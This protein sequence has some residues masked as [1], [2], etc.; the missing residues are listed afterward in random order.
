MTLHECAAAALGG[1][2]DARRFATHSFIELGGDSLRA[3]R[4]VALARERLGVRIPVARLLSGAPLDEILAD[5][6]AADAPAPVPAAPERAAISATQRGMW[7]I[8][9]F[10]GGSPYNLVFACVT[11]RGELAEDHLATAVQ[12]TVDRHE[13]LRTVFREEDGDVVR[14]VVTPFAAPFTRYVDDGAAG[15]FDGFVR[16]IAT[17]TGRKPFDLTAAP[18]VRFAFL[19]GTGRA[20]LVVQAHHM[21][22]D[23]W[24]VGLLLKE[25]FTRYDALV[26]GAADPLPEAGIGVRVLAEHQEATRGDRDRQLAFW[27]TQ[28]DGVPSVLELPADR[29]RP[30]EQ[31]ASGA[32]LPLDL[33][34]AVSDAVATRANTLGV[35]RFAV[36]LAAFGLTLS[37][38][39]GA[40][41]LLIGVPLTGRGTSELAE[42]V[43]VTGNLVPVRVDV[44]DD[45]PAAEYVRSVQE[46]LARSMEAGDLPFEEIVA[47]LGV[48]RTLGAHPLVQVCFGMHDQLVPPRLSTPDV[49]LRVDELHGG[50]AQFDLTLLI[51][52]SE[53]ALAGHVE[54]ATAVWSEAEASAFAADFREA[55]GQLAAEGDPALEEVRCL[56]P[57]RR[58]LLTALNETRREF[59]RVTLDALFRKIAGERP[60]APAVRAGDTELSYAE[61]ARAVR[62][63]AELLRA[64]GV[65][66]GDRVLV[67]LD[68]SIAEVVAVLGTVSVGAAYVGVELDQP[69]AHTD[70]ILASAAPAAALV[71]PRSADRVR[72]IPVVEAWRADWPAPAGEPVF[73]GED[74]DRPAYVAFT[75]GSTGVPK[76]VVVPQR[77]VLRLV[78][79][80]GYVRLGPGERMLRLS[81][82]AFDAST[83][84][85]WG[86]LLTGATLEVY[87]AGFAAPRELGE[88]LHE[89]E[90]TVAWLTAGLFRLVE[91]FA[92][93]TLGT[94]RQLLTGGDVVP[95]DHVARLLRRHP[96]LVVTNGY[97]P[98]ENTT[99]TTTCSVREPDEVAGPLPIGTPLPGTRVYVL[100]ERRRLVPPGAVGELYT[101]G[102]GLALGYLGDEAETG[103][104]FGRF[105]PEV[106]ERLYRTG[107]LVRLDSQ[108]QLRFLGRGDDQVKLRGYR[109]ELS[110]ISDVLAGQPGVQDAV[111]VV[112]GDDSATKR[113]VAGIV[114]AAGQPADTAALRA[115]LAQRLPAYMVPALW[116]VLERIPLT[117]NGKVDRRA[118]SAGAGP[119]SAPPAEADEPGLAAMIALLTETLDGAAAE[120]SADTDFFTI[121]GNSMGAVRLIRLIRDRLGVR[122][123]LRDF[124]RTPTAAGLQL[125]VRKASAA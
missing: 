58:A 38:W 74:P 52:R 95:H 35:T 43:A 54:Y 93:D 124:L 7:L 27:R 24:S 82:L 1:E 50:G 69:A 104:R 88:F 21:V 75:S 5:L 18:G 85:L 78:H 125:L 40:R 8:E 51:G 98:T 3:M 41:R 90:V 113:L 55:V 100:D 116:S 62:R 94:L 16:R 39:T 89:R 66:P 101:G 123:Q 106:P 9:R 67:A 105:S 70:R 79:K 119:A 10:T 17:E 30:A 60:A 34:P 37:R 71:E 86:A 46:S 63:Q 59:P 25:I 49:E 114:P 76:G 73:P 92:G 61:L 12:A 87:P 118:L 120:I 6:P 117:G 19:T 91:E 121:G 23:G 102:E 107:D 83:L 15:E 26:R 97:G 44:D 29:Q 53:P 28:L 68:R 77:A 22:L 11:E 14:K 109:I 103:R 99:F 96:G 48:E 112:A 31:D 84:E 64:A 36:L 45:R 57:E 32:R 110:A 33:G 115:A 2:A 4:F 72:G 13:N 111:V 80:V 122:V 42:L 20:A 56:A 81:P 47:A 108:G 65:G